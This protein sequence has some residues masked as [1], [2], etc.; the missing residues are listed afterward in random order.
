MRATHI[1]FCTFDS[2]E[3]CEELVEGEFLSFCKRAC[4]DD[5][6][7]IENEAR[8]FVQLRNAASIRRGD[9][10]SLQILHDYYAQLRRLASPLAEFEEAYGGHIKYIWRDPRCNEEYESPSIYFDLAAILFNIA[11][12]YSESACTE[13]LEDEAS[14]VRAGRGFAIAAGNATGSHTY[15]SLQCLSSSP[16]CFPSH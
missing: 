13:S 10:N 1:K 8:E 9:E 7:S 2:L 16:Q 15:I 4:F 6:V 12:S 11:A 14:A 5:S 3:C